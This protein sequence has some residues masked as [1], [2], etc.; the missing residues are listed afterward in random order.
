MDGEQEDQPIRKP[1]QLAKPGLLAERAVVE[2][3]HFG[4][5]RRPGAICSGAVL[6]GIAFDRRD[7]RNPRGE[8]C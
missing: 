8:A 3:E 4:I 7:G 2:V 6:A 5:F 1:K